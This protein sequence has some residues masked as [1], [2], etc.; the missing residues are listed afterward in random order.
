V[1]VTDFF[2]SFLSNAA[3]FRRKQKD[4]ISMN[5]LKKERVYNRRKGTRIETFLKT[6]HPSHYIV[7]AAGFD[8][9]YFGKV[10]LFRYRKG[11]LDNHV[12]DTHT[13]ARTMTCMCGLTLLCVIEYKEDVRK[14]TWPTFYRNS[15][16]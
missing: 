2:Q 11:K 14:Y 6:F 7:K 4:K 9:I 1:G 3:R 15:S 10:S 13:R 8:S 16:I 12:I 5:K